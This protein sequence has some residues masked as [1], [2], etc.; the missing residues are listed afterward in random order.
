M[1]LRPPSANANNHLSIYVSSHT[2]CR[3]ACRMC[4]LT[5]T[6]QTSMQSVDRQ[7]FR[8]QIQQALREYTSQPKQ[9]SHVYINFMARGEPLMNAAIQRGEMAD[10]FLEWQ[11]L[12]AREAGFPT[13]RVNVSTIMPK[14]VEQGPSLETMF[15]VALGRQIRLYSSLYSQRDEFRRVWLPQAMPVASALSKLHAWSMKS[16]SPITFHWPLIQGHN[17]DVQDAQDLARML[18]KDFYDTGRYQL[19]RFNSPDLA[20]YKE[21]SEERRRLVFDALTKAFDDPSRSKR[22]DRV[23]EDV[24]ASCGTFFRA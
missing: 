10:M 14:G 7:G 17:D 5:A 22:I 15:P 21:A 12:C 2:G 3:M 19:V 13:L 23:G 9:A 24:F 6:G 8:R 4:H 20:R 11:D 16:R 1:V 18:K